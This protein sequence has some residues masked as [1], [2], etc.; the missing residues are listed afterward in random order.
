MKAP[1]ALSFKNT[2]PRKKRGREEVK[3]DK[4]MTYI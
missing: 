2:E 3:R 1:K 4:E